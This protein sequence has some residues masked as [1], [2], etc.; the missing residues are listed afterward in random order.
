MSQ[1]N[2]RD[3]KK[4]AMRCGASRKSSALRVGGVSTTMRSYVALG[5]DLV[6]PLHGDVVVRLDEAPRDVL[7]E[8]VGQDLLPRRLVGRMRGG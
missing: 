1:R 6:E 2:R 4:S 5:V 3:E 7:V 8:R